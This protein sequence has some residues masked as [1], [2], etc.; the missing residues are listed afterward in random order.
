[1]QSKVEGNQAFRKTNLL[2]L[3][4]FMKLLTKSLAAIALAS[5]TIS[6]PFV[7]NAFVQES[8]H[9]AYL[10]VITTRPIPNEMGQPNP[11]PRN[12]NPIESRLMEMTSKKALQREL[13]SVR[14][15]YQKWEGDQIAMRTQTRLAQIIHLRAN[16][17]GVVLQ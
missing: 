4:V 10:S 3:K 17:V 9:N 16:Q 12:T 15:N 8:S 13:D 14:A 1:M 7:A 2:L 11:G 5:F 6:I